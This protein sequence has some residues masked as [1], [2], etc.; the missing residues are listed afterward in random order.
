MIIWIFA[1]LNRYRYMYMHYTLEILI[2]NMF[3]TEKK[4]KIQ[5]QQ[6]RFVVIPFHVYK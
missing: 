6:L 2:K 1:E 3:Y 4:K 5:Q